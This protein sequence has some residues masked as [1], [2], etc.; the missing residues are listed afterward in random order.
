M[1]NTEVCLQKRPTLGQICRFPP[2]LDGEGRRGKARSMRRADAG[3]AHQAKAGHCARL[4]CFS[5]FRGCRSVDRQA[6]SIPAKARLLLRNQRLSKRYC[7]FALGAA[8]PLAS[9]FN[10]AFK[11][12]L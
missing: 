11:R 12:L 5:G 10:R 1:Q 6:T 9:A 8:A 7:F 2:I 4:L 3:L